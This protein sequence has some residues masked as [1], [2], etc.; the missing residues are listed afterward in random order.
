[1]LADLSPEWMKFQEILI[2][3]DSMLKKH[4]EKFKTGLLA[5]SEEF[6]KQV[7]SL[8]DDFHTRGHCST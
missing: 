6:K 8:V 1:M 5:Q 4:K 7:S 3:A 2:E